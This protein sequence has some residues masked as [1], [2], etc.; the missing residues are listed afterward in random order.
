[1]LYNSTK[2]MSQPKFVDFYI[3]GELPNG[4]VGASFLISRNEYPA[5]ATSLNYTTTVSISA[6]Q[7][8]ATWTDRVL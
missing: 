3:F 4:F 1:M 6:L 2:A 8:H 5:N 7:A